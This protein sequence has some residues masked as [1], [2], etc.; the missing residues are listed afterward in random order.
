MDKVQALHQAYRTGQAIAPFEVSKEEALD[1]FKKFSSM[2]VSEEGLGGY[3]ISLVR[4]EHLERFGGDEPMYGVLTKKMI[5]TEREVK[6]RFPKNFAELEVVL[7]AR[8]CNPVNIPECVKGTFIG[9]E[10]PSTRF[11]TWKLTA[12]QLLA[13]DSA[14][15]SLFLG[16]E[17]KLPLRGSMYL[18]GEKVGEDSP[19]FLL[20][21]PL[22][23]LK[24]LTERI[25][26][27]NGFVSSG[28]FVGPVEVK[29]GDTLVAECC[30]EEI[31]VTLK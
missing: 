16:Y 9:I 4:K 22:E 30:G 21:G 1:I 18:N 2:L 15:G 24:W 11:N 26:V 3:K 31:K 19:T 25:G 7:Q 23:M 5:T 13:D 8:G 6:L 12:T 28:V 14:A 10:L 27:V 29:K 17:V 20:G